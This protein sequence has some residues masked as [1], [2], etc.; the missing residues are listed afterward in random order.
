[1][2]IGGELSV[3]T[4]SKTGYKLSKTLSYAYS[5]VLG[6]LLKPRDILL[7]FA[8]FYYILHYKAPCYGHQHHFINE[9]STY[10][11]S[12]KSLNCSRNHKERNVQVLYEHDFFLFWGVEG[13]D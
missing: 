4:L 3:K 6:V 13:S 1:M 10:N 11:L 2:F 12:Q 7:Q 8:Y 9:T 5:S